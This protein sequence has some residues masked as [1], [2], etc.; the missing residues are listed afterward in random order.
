MVQSETVGAQRLTKGLPL[1]KA[2]AGDRCHDRV[3]DRPKP[4]PLSREQFAGSG[5]SDPGQR[6]QRLEQD[7]ADPV[8][9]D[10]FSLLGEV[11]VLALLGVADP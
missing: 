2:G 7:P 4:R 9:N 3:I 1:V 6:P 10:R 8:V 5:G 11:P